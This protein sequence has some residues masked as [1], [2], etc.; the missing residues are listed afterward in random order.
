MRK[1]ATVLVLMICAVSDLFLFC[2]CVHSLVCV[3]G[4]ETLTGVCIQHSQNQVQY[5]LIHTS[6]VAEEN[7]VKFDNVETFIGI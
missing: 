2:S 7:N 1:T 3:P 5:I 4:N 6:A